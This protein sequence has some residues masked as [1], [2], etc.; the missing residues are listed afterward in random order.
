V[1]DTVA[2][3][4]EITMVDQPKAIAFDVDPLSLRSLQEALPTWQIE[5][6]NGATTASLTRDWKP[7]EADLL[8]IGARAEMSETLGLCRGLRSQLGRAHTALLVL[9]AS[10]QEPLVRAALEA[11]ANSCLVLPAHPKELADMVARVQRDNQ[12]GRHTLDLD[13]AQRSDR[14]RDDGGEA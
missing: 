8:V 2:S 12:P 9:V 14:W 5:P 6:I 3:S 7:G 4:R 11:G 10:A 13:P 1:S